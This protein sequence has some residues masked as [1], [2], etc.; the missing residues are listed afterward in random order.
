METK[1]IV[2][3]KDGQPCGKDVVL[4]DMRIGG[5]VCN[6]H[7]WWWYPECKEFHQFQ[8]LFVYRDDASVFVHC[9]ETQKVLHS[10]FR[11][12]G[13]RFKAGH[14]PCQKCAVLH[15]LSFQERSLA[16]ALRTTSSR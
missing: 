15:K 11:S 16:W 12:R 5:P 7:R 6:E 1:C 3:G 2:E 4:V 9:P 14:E 8:R 13:P 10:D